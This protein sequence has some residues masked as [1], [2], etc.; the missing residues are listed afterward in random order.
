[1]TTD[2]LLAVATPMHIIAP[3]SAGTLKVVWVMKSVQAMPASAHGSAV[4]MPPM[5]IRKPAMDGQSLW[6]KTPRR[7]DPPSR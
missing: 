2:T 4:M 6:D 3:I 1:V 5:V 7:E